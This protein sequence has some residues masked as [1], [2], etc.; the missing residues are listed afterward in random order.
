MPLIEDGMRYIEPDADD[1]SFIVRRST[2]PRA[3]WQQVK[4][5]NS[6][7]LNWFL[8]PVFWLCLWVVLVV[9]NLE[10]VCFRSQCRTCRKKSGG[11]DQMLISASC[12]CQDCA[13]F[14]QVLS[15]MAPQIRLEHGM[16]TLESESHFKKFPLELSVFNVGSFEAAKFRFHAPRG[17]HVLF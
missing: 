12:G 16:F 14:V 11:A 4:R 9:K 15:E 5:T 6:P 8:R 17:M 13:L 7:I 10:G 1:Q 3:V 2:G